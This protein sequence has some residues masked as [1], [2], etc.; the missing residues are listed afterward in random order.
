MAN[1]KNTRRAPRLPSSGLTRNHRGSFASATRNIRRVATIILVLFL[2]ITGVLWLR[3]HNWDF[4]AGLDSIIENGQ[5]VSTGFAGSGVETYSTASQVLE[6]IEVTKPYTGS[7]YQRSNF[8]KAWEDID[9]NGCDQRNDILTRDLTSL[10]VATN[11]K[12]LSG[13]LIDPYTAETIEFTRGAQSSEAV[14]ID[15]VVSLSNAWSSGAWQWNI[16]Q[17]TLLA[18]DPL[19]LQASSQASNT[20]KSDKDAASWLPQTGYR[21]EYVARQISVKAAYNLTVTSAEKKAMQ[22]V[23][24]TCPDQPAYRSVFAGN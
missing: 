3:S 11:C 1:F 21:C 13:T 12:V 6:T 18:N 24:A 23:L 2:L 5:P 14:P 15:H 19:N 8:G 7:R 10:K 16:E 20:T 9:T 4:R 17:R 22:G